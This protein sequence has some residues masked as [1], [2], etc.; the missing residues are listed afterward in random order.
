[1]NSSQIKKHSIAIKNSFNKD[2]TRAG[3][4]EI[5]WQ[6]SIC[7]H[8]QLYAQHKSHYFPAIGPGFHPDVVLDTGNRF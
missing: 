7:Y 8:N 5:L 4:G 6:A 3:Y 1:M 2:V